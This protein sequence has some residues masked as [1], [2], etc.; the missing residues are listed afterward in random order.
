MKLPGVLSAIFSAV[1]F[2]VSLVS[3]PLTHA[4]SYDDMLKSVKLGD[5]ATVR[6]LLGRG[7]DVNTSD[8]EG[9]TLL[10][11]A[12]RENRTELARL[13]I[14]ERAKLNARNMHGDSALKIAA[15]NGSLDIVRE[16]V[17][18]GAEIDTEGWT[19]LIYA[20]FNGHDDIVEFLLQQGAGIDARSESGMTALMAAARGGFLPIVDRLLAAGASVNLHDA[21]GESALD[22]A[23]KTKNTNIAAR[24]EAAGGQ[25]GKKPRRRR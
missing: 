24:L 16:L 12:A 7:M 4:S 19:P 10:M 17:Q 6:N 22:W 13:F 3:A 2:A 25:P 15:Y 1:V 14:R 18:A 11:L 8:R 20:A 23:N 5:I 9:N 21:N